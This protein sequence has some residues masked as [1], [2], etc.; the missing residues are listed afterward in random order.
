MVV[1]LANGIHSA[2]AGTRIDALVAHTGAIPRAIRIEYTLR[3]ATH[4]GITLIFGD[5]SALTRLAVGIGATRRWLARIILHW[6]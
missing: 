3:T 6:S 2:G 5:T 4:I 1:H